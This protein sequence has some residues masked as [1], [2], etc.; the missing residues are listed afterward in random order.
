MNR[1][2]KSARFFFFLIK[3]FNLVKNDYL[4]END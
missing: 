4:L 2:K 1:V 3:A